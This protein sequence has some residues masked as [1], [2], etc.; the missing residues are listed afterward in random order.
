MVVLPLADVEKAVDLC[1]D[2]GGR[3]WTDATARFVVGFVPFVGGMGLQLE[4]MWLQIRVLGIIAALY[5]HDVDTVE[6]QQQIIL[7][8]MD[9]V[10]GQAQSGKLRSEMER[11]ALTQVATQRRLRSLASCC[12]CLSGADM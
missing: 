8:L 4:Q 3:G 1:A 12:V 6:V 11:I 5:G 2:M 9:A 7:C 10:A